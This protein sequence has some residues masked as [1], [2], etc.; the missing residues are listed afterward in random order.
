MFHYGSLIKVVDPL[1]EPARI[2]NM[3]Y[4]LIRDMNA[5]TLLK[6]IKEIDRFNEEY[7]KGR[8]LGFL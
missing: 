8:R 5:N 1:N 6:Q 3:I 7:I 2:H 4:K